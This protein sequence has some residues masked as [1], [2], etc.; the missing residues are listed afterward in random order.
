MKRFT[1][2]KDH[3]PGELQAMIEG[4]LEIKANGRTGN[5]LAGKSAALCFMNPSLRTMTSFSTAVA[6]L[7][8]HPIVLTPG[9]NA[10]KM[11]S[12]Q[13]VVMDG[14]AAEHAVDAARVLSRY[15]AVIGLRSFPEG[16]VWEEDRREKHLA[17]FI[18]E[19]SVPVVNLESATGH[20]CQALADMMTIRERMRPAGK[21]FLLTWA[22]HTKALPTAVARSAAEIAAAAG[23]DV[24]IAR[25]EG[26]D[27]SPQAMAQI[28][29]FAGE[30]GATIEVT[31][32]VE[33]AYRGAH[34]VYA[35]SWGSL[36]NY[37]SP[38]PQ[39][40]ACRQ[41]WIVD[42]AKM[43]RT[44]NAIF[45]HCLPVRRNLVVSDE[46]LDGP[47]SAVYDQAENRLHTAIAILEYLLSPSK[48]HDQ[49]PIGA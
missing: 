48:S 46:V 22:P 41:K 14:P 31:D 30:T 29:T 6:Q 19:A 18:K 16:K 33:S 27:L 4:A 12:E 15:A 9:A 40:E 17:A 20:P 38:P 44:D 10:W 49:V 42:G 28:R 24:T 7:G 1:H 36:E 26:Y 45:M 39:E 37:G 8:G 32:D 13:G 5:A 21:K 2:L 25:P 23:M 43:S 35:K 11:E 3:T 47:R 34:V